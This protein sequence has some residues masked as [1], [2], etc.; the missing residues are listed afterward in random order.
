MNEPRSARR[1][2]FTAFT[3]IELLVVIAIISILI[4]LLLPAIGEARRAAKQVVCTSNL[5]Q[6]VTGINTYA[7]ENKDQIV[8]APLTSGYAAL[9]LNQFNGVA[10][11]EYDY[12]GPLA[13]HMGYSGPGE[14]HSLAELT[15][16]VRAQRF[17]WYRKL[18]AFQCP[19]NN[20]LA[21]AYP[22]PNN[23]V[24]VSGRMLSFN[25][26][27]QFTSTE[28][29][30]NEGGTLN[31]VNQGIDRKGYKPFLYRVGTSSLKA[32]I[33][34]GHRY[35]TPGDEPD[36]DHALQ[37]KYGGAFGG[38]GPWYSDNKELNR[39]QAP[40]EGVAIPTAYDAR[41]WGFRHGGRVQSYLGRSTV[42]CLGDVGFFDG[43]VALMDD[44]KATN[45]DYWFP[46]GSRLNVG[47]RNLDTWQYT[48]T[49]FPDKTG[50]RGEYNVP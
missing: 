10:M 50:S 48:R 23:P 4:S 22:N 39:G 46:T 9:K 13:A 44:G 34:D 47:G 27:T 36:Y 40:G 35:A 25:M 12:V 18:E 32:A 5:R 6:I 41:R 49:A 2:S 19:E 31:R 16:Q 15:E 43:H 21:V 28:G 30:L 3:L 37:A 14:G 45:P 42:Q 17:I 20:I 24:W 26:S 29:A 11:Q 38:T 1:P 8:G 33:F 7:N